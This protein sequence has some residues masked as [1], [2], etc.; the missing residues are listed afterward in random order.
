MGRI[1]LIAFLVLAVADVFGQ[2]RTRVI[3]KNSDN[4]RLH[5]TMAENLS[6]VLTEFNQAFRESRDPRMESQR[7][8]SE[9]NPRIKALWKTA[10]FYSPETEIMENLLA[11]PGGGFQI[12]NIQL[13]LKSKT[14]DIFQ[15]EAV[16]NFSPGGLIEDLY[17]GI[18]QHRYKALMAKGISLQDFRR[19]QIILDFLENFRTAYN[20]KDLEMLEKTFS[21][22]ALI[23]V[24]KVMT[25]VPNSPEMMLSLGDKKVEL[26]KYSKRQYLTNLSAVFRQNT[27]L[28]VRFDEIQIVQHPGFEDIYG[29]NLQQSW[30]SSTYSDEG[31]IFLM[32]DFENENKPLVHVRAWQPFKETQRK[33][34]IEL[35]DFDI[36][37]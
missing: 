1:L 36:I 28:D 35:G 12:R 27:F 9:A 18:E 6:A 37:K 26:I 11:M 14:G 8:D 15:Q 21:D 7:M 17:L 3:F 31:Y 19:R 5:L 13:S 20:R 4:S 22:N 23:I 33:D 16:V 24:G 30:K 32:I 10:A 25:E 34:V 29:V 2:N